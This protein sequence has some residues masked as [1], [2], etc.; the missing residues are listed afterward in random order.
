MVRDLP[1]FNRRLAILRLLLSQL[2][3][4]FRLV[5]GMVMYTNAFETNEK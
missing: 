5:L 2:I 4:I 3:F 1:W